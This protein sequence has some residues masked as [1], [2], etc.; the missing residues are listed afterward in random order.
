[1]ARQK[2]N[3]HTYSQYLDSPYRA[4]YTLRQQVQLDIANNIAPEEYAGNLPESVCHRLQAHVRS[5]R[6][7]GRR[8][9]DEVTPQPEASS[10]CLQ[11]R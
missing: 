1:M 5:L 8:E 6:A 3:R 10:N 7:E 11:Q 9:V 2:H 4:R